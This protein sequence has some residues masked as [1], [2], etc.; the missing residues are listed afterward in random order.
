MNL[1][2]FA[3]PTLGYNDLDFL[4]VGQGAQTDAEYTAQ[5]TLS[6]LGTRSV[7]SHISTVLPLDAACLATAIGIRSCA[8]LSSA[9]Q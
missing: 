8:T 3:G 4:T 5:V 9:Q 1:D 2:A 6:K 7:H